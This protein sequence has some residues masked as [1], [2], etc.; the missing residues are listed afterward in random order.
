MKKQKQKFAIIVCIVIALIFLA[1][2]L[3]N[4]NSSNGSSDQPAVTETTTP[5]KSTD[6]MQSSIAESTTP[7]STEPQETMPVIK[8]GDDVTVW[9]TE[10]DPNEKIDRTIEIDPIH[11]EYIDVIG[12]DPYLCS[13]GKVY[14]NDKLVEIEV[15][16]KLNPNNKY[17][18]N[19]GYATGTC[20]R[21]LYLNPSV[22]MNGRPALHFVNMRSVTHPGTVFP[23]TTQKVNDKKF[24]PTLTYS[25]KRHYENVTAA[26]FVSPKEPG[27]VWFTQGPADGPIYVDILVNTIDCR[28][29]ATLRMT[30]AKDESDGTYS[31]VDLDNMDLLNNN[32]SHPEF[33]SKELNQAFTVAK[34]A[35]LDVDIGGFF[36]GSNQVLEMNK[37]II[38]YMA[39]EYGLHF[40]TFIPRSG[41]GNNQTSYYSADSHTPV[42]AVT[43]GVG[44]GNSHTMYVQV[45]KEP[46]EKNPGEYF[47][48]GRDYPLYDNVNIMRGY[49]WEG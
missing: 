11:P 49:G 47:Y 23:I 44:G 20:N 40:P 19:F 3:S 28:T 15:T 39:P 33:T 10:K 31:I 18:I 27:V 42:I 34:E 29:I 21:F 1:F 2:L 41:W 48:V 8:W 46:T 22:K 26:H 16:D 43:I 32:S 14:R 30:I 45:I 36:S 9:Q 5:I 17:Q 13:E 6:T 35:Y 25:Y 7:V 38:E 12:G 37:C 4:K 24:E